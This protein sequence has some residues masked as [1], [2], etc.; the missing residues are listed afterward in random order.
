MSRSTQWLTA[1]S[2]ALIAAGTAQAQQ[3]DP[4]RF[5]LGASFGGL[6]GAANLDNSGTVD[7]R[8]G[9]A[10]S[11]DATYWIQRY[12]GVRATGTWGQDSVRGNPGSI[13]GR[14]KF[15]KFYYGGDLV[16]RYPLQAGRYLITPY[17]LGGAGAV[18]YHQLGADSTFTKF[19]GDFGAGL[20][21]RFDRFGVRAQG[22]DFVSKFDRF[23]F[24]RTQHDI[25]WDAGLTVSF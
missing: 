24:D 21:Y 7:W 16:L 19:A 5:T 4:R 6:S 3:V 13:A 12:V 15:N 22:R 23:G 25:V 14:Q 11:A 18:S 17:V 8:L 10:A 2:L 9:W 20:E 1:L